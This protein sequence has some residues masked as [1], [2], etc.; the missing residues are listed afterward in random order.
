MLRHSECFRSFGGNGFRFEQAQ[1]CSIEGGHLWWAEKKPFAAFTQEWIWIPSKKDGFEWWIFLIFAMSNCWW[2]LQ[3][4][5]ANFFHSHSADFSALPGAIQCDPVRFLKSNHQHYP[6][7]NQQTSNWD[8]IIGIMSL[9]P[10]I[11]STYDYRPYLQ[12]CFVIENDSI[13]LFNKLS[14]WMGI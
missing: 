9:I 8:D 7:S 13:F 12:I 14:Q 6:P 10:Y 11:R 3:A 4:L 2:W 5:C 1:L